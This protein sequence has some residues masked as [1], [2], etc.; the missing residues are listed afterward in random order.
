MYPMISEEKLYHVA[1]QVSAGIDR[2]I[3]R[4]MLL[5]EG[6][7]AAEIEDAFARLER[8]SKAPVRDPEP[9]LEPAAAPRA[10]KKRSAARPVVV[11]EEPQEK[12]TVRF[13]KSAGPYLVFPAAC[14]LVWVS[15][16]PFI[17]MW[18]SAASRSMLAALD[19]A[20]ST[21]SQQDA[22]SIRV[23]SLPEIHANYPAVA[24]QGAYLAI[25]GTHFDD[26]D[27]T[28]EMR[29]ATG[30][31]YFVLGAVH[32]GTM[33]DAFILPQKIPAGPYSLQVG[34]RFGTSSAYAISVEAP[35][36]APTLPS[37]ESSHTYMTLSP[38][39]CVVKGS[40]ACTAQ[41]RWDN[42]ATSTVAALWVSK[43][44]AEPQFVSCEAGSTGTS[45]VPGIL[46]GSVYEFILY[47]AS[48]CAPHPALPKE[49]QWLAAVSVTGV[50][51][52]TARYP[53]PN[54][55]SVDLPLFEQ[56]EG[57]ASGG[58]GDA[59]HIAVETAMARKALDDAKLWGANF[60][61]VG[62]TGET[63]ADLV[64]WE[65]D[66]QTYW[67]LMD[68]MI[69]DMNVRGLAIVPVFDWNS[70]VFPALADETVTD[71]YGKRD[72]ASYQLFIQYVTQFI[73]RYKNDPQASIY[74]YEIGGEG[75]AQADLDTAS[76][77]CAE[78]HE[79]PCTAAGNF[80]T[81]QLIAFQTRV[82]STMRTLDP[83]R[84]VA[85]AGNALALAS[86]MQQEQ[87]P[88]WYGGSNFTPDTYDEF[89]RYLEHLDQGMDMID[90]H[91]YNTPAAIGS[92]N[93][94]FCPGPDCSIGKNNAGI[95]A[96]YGRVAEA[97]AIP[98]VVGAFGDD[99][100]FLNSLLPQ[101]GPFE[102]DVFS[103][104]QSLRIGYAAPWATEYYS[105]LTSTYNTPASFDNI[106]P[107][108]TDSLIKLMAQ[109]NKSIGSSSKKPLDATPAV[110]VIQT[111][112]LSGAAL[113]G[114]S[115]RLYAVASAP[116][117]G[118]L[119][120]QVQFTVDGKVIAT[121][122]APPYSSTIEN[123]SLSP[124]S[125]TFMAFA[126]DDRGV[127]ATSSAAIVTCSP[128]VCSSAE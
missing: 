18:G 69:H 12:R 35:A 17:G 61:R 119:I 5:C 75:N 71:F 124:G 118:R 6:F 108:Y 84:P 95:L 70:A 60:V 4:D 29:G 67:T 122:H 102:Q 107:G 66:P 79:W 113:S 94:R 80:T 93:E 62:V 126:A 68:S 82:A 46:D 40:S 38:G 73:S 121:V 72:S 112:P 25:V 104:I 22:D 97:M 103:K 42:P 109:V 125:H 3:V 117:A 96:E 98:V 27:N 99:H 10:A 128:S 54:I 44:A 106:E 65:S 87:T 45:S 114:L 24:M 57:R 100:P 81:N 90:V 101:V 115:T 58:N 50:S 120:R 31:S 86:A 8:I 19:A 105:S 127:I 21:A 37:L 15:M 78:T 91:L 16:Q 41:I 63:P 74:Y 30:T 49:S 52:S 7:S 53:A 14:L 36:H 11:Y 56:Y 39:R 34:N 1:L 26:A 76:A 123:A 51:S 55:G 33:L 47:A 92:V 28:L 32:D 85:P 88:A 23:V 48:S 116:R 59:A 111:S 77:D 13:A 43:D 89:S 20:S 9:T 2:E 110:E 83:T 64:M